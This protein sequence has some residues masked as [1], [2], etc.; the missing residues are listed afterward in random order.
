MLRTVRD[1]LTEG[2]RPMPWRKVLMLILA[3]VVPAAIAVPFMGRSGA[4]AFVAAMPACLAAQD[5]GIRAAALVT[6]VMGMAGMLSLGQPDM[7]LVIAPVLALM[8][9]VCGSF[10]LARPAIRP[11]LIWPIFTSPI[12]ASDNLPLS[13]LIF[14]VSMLWS[15]AVTRAFSGTRSQDPEDVESDRYAMVF[16][17]VLAVGLTLS[18]WLGNR[19]FGPH[20]F[21]FPLTFMILVLPPHGH[22]FRRTVKRT[23][24]TLA[25]TAVALFLATLVE[26]TWLLAVIGA[27]CLPLGFRVMPR[28]YTLFTAFLTVTVLEVLALVSEVDRLAFE[29]VGTMAAAAL[30]TFALGFLGWAVL[31]LIEPEALEALQ[32]AGVT[33]TPL[34]GERRKDSVAS[35]GRAG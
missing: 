26:A 24:G 11:L 14:S 6:M 3:I 10:G 2:A 9:G 21:W 27:A 29:R 12:I 18:V 22:L 5:A 7:A 17:I 34:G 32:E 20:G 8:V 13:F 35:A 19:Y 4:I 16:G 33:E 23:I 15:L 25:G 1:W 30:T 31:R 28:S